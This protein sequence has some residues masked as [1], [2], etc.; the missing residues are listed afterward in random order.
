MLPART[1]ISQTP[2]LALV[3][4]VASARAPQV[5]ISSLPMNNDLADYFAVFA[6]P[7]VPAA[8][9]YQPARGARRVH[10]VLEAATGALVIVSR[11]DWLTHAE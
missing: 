7:V 8:G 3:R 11:S 5:V 1:T 6:A 10:A 2:L 4:V 9:S